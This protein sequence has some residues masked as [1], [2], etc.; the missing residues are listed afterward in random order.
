MKQLYLFTFM[1]FVSITAC[2]T[3]QKAKQNVRTEL[4]TAIPDMIKM[5]ESE[6]YTALFNTYVKPE[7]LEHMTQ[8]ESLDELIKNFVENGKSEKLLKALK[9]AQKVSPMYNE[10]KTE[11]IYKKEITGLKRDLILTKINGFWYIAN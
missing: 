1:I 4:E 10:I 6:E 8:K 3:T 5:I 7:D 2:K 11:A 9:A